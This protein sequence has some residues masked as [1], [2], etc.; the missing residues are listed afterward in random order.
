MGDKLVWD[1]RSEEFLLRLVYQHK[2]YSMSKGNTKEAWEQIREALNSEFGAS[3]KQHRTVKAKFAKM[4]AMHRSRSQM[5]SSS[6]SS[7]SQPKQ[8]SSTRSAARNKHQLL[9][10]IHT[11]EAAGS[12]STNS[13]SSSSLR[14]NDLSINWPNPD[15][16]MAG[17][18]G[19]ATGESE[20]NLWTTP[21]GTETRPSEGVPAPLQV[22][23]THSF[24]LPSKR[25]RTTKSDDPLLLELLRELLGDSLS[26]GGLAARMEVLEEKMAGEL[27]ALRLEVAL[28]RLEVEQ[29]RY[30]GRAARGSSVPM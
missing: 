10:Q 13:S 30:R 29:I 12:R 16:D 24:R 8:A 3:V 26:S 18:L 17:E 25:A 22:H 11:E 5:D 6:T 21:L 15:Y 28:L 19:P 7:A 9:Q 27:A 14:A 23:V 20:E 4:L 1:H 2:P